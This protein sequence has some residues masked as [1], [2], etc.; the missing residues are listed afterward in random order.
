MNRIP[1]RP[2][3][4]LSDELVD[5]FAALRAENDHLRAQLK[6]ITHVTRETIIYL[7]DLEEKLIR[8]P[9]NSGDNPT[10]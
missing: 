4:P 2:P 7:R 8:R 6:T 9:S 10:R 5:D 1:R 3:D